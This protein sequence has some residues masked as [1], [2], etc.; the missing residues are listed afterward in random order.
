MGIR[1]VKKKDRIQKKELSF[2]LLI[3]VIASSILEL[4]E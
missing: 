2:K 4:T 1:K 3:I